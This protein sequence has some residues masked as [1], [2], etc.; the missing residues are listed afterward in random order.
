MRRLLLAFLCLSAP[1]AAQ[2]LPLKRALPAATDVACPAFPAPPTPVRAQLD[3]ANR[4]A[5]LSAEAALEGDHKSAR[6]LFQQASQLNQ[7]DAS[8]AYRLGREDEEMS[9]W[10]AATRE[11]CRYLY[12]SPTAGDASQIRDKL[13]ALL[14]SSELG[15]GTTMVERFHAGLQHY[16]QSDWNAA[17]EAFTAVTVAAPGFAPAYFDRALALARAHQRPAAIRDFD[18]Y[19]ALVPNAGDR[20]TVRARQLALRHE[21]PSATTAFW[22]GLLPGAGQYY[23][24]QPLLG[25]LVTGAAAGAVVWS[26]QTQTVTK[27]ATFTD[28]NG[29][30][31][32]QTYP[33]TERKNLAAGIGA[34]AGV[35]LLGAI[36][37]AI[38][39]HNRSSGLPPL[40]DTATTRVSRTL[41]PR[42]TA[43]SMI[44]GP[45]HL[46]LALG[47]EFR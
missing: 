36:Q 11:Y 27:T 9:D 24:R 46:G 13:T 1:L 23:T 43:P 40:A 33:A 16:D 30:P 10:P 8:L 26:V 32:Q 37:A 42:L 2:D 14:P 39:A 12:L 25:V 34:A 15:R 3:E 22:L 7:V 4:L 6:D 29:H 19:L 31:Y 38:V 47:L 20:V 45:G 28:G 21:L 17:I 18:R 41:P 35:T 44:A 5:T